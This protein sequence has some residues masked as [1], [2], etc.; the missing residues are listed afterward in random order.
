MTPPLEETTSVQVAFK[1]ANSSSV[2][3]DVSAQL[4]DKRNGFA[5]DLEC[6]N[7]KKF[8]SGL[9]TIDD[10]S[11]SNINS[12][13]A[14][15][16][17]VGENST[18]TNIQHGFADGASYALKAKILYKDSA[19]VI[20]T[21]YA[22][23]SYG[24]DSGNQ[25]L[26]S[27]N[28]LC[29]EDGGD[30]FDPEESLIVNPSE[31]ENGSDIVISCPIVRRQAE[32]GGYSGFDDRVPHTVMFT[33]D[34]VDDYYANDN[35]DNSEQITH[36]TASLPYNAEGVYTLVDCSLSNDSAYIVTVSA[37]YSDGHTVHAT[38]KDVCNAITAPVINSVT[39]YGLGDLQKG[40]GDSG[41]S[42]VME[43]Y[44][45]AA[46]APVK[47]PTV[48]NQIK[49]YLKQGD[50]VMYSVSLDRT[51]DIVDNQVKY[52][53][54]KE[55]LV[56]EE[57][58]EPV[59]NPNGS[60]TFD[61]TAT[62]DYVP[63]SQGSEEGSDIT[64]TSNIVSK[65]FTSDITPVT[66]VTISNAWI[67]A[68]VTTVDG[69]R[70]VDLNDATS[71]AGYNDAPVFAIAGQ[72][73]KNAFFGS[74]KWEGLHQDLDTTETKFKFMMRKNHDESDNP[75]A[76]WVPI[77]KLHL[78]QG[79]GE[80]SDQ[81]NVVSLVTS[82][83]KTNADGLFANIPGEAGV[84][85]SDQPNLYFMVPRNQGTSNLFNQEDSVE[86]S[87]QIVANSENT[88][89]DATASNK[90]VV[91]HKVRKY[92]QESEPRFTGSGSFGTLEVPIS[93]P[94]TLEGDYN[95]HSATF[96]S[97]L[98]SPNNSVTENVSNDGVFDLTV[99]DPSKR[100]PSNAVNYTVHYNISDPNGDDIRGPVSDSYEIYLNDEP[101]NENFSITEY[102]YKTFNNHGES[103]FQFKV[104]FLDGEATRADGINV[105][106]ESENNDSVSSN[107]ISKTL[108]CN[109]LRAEHDS[110]I[111][112]IVVLQAADPA[113]SSASDGVK[114]L[115]K[116]GVASTNTWFN[117][118]SG[119]V[120]FRAY[121]TPRVDSSDDTQFEASGYDH[122]E[123]IN[124][125]PRIDPVDHASVS[126]T[127]GVIESHRDT[128]MEWTNELSTKYGA[129]NNIVATH[130]VWVNDVD[131]TGD[132][133][134]GSDSYTVDISGD[135]YSYSLAL[136]VKIVTTN[137]ATTYY[138]RDIILDFD[139]VSVNTEPMDVTVARGSNDQQLKASFVKYSV[140]PDESKLN[141]TAVLLV[142]NRTAENTDPEEANVS[143]LSHSLTIQPT[144]VVNTYNISEYS[145]GDE[146]RLV[147]SVE[148][149]VDY[150]VSRIVSDDAATP[151][152]YSLDGIRRTFTD[153]EMTGVKADSTPSAITT[154]AGQDGWAI[155]NLVAGHKVNLYYYANTISAASTNAQNSFTLSQASGLGLY[156]IF[157]QNEDAK[158]YPYFIA[159]TVP[160]GTG[161]KASW[162]KSKVFISPA[163]AQP[164]P[165]G[166]PLYSGLTLAYSGTD[167]GSFPDIPAERRV[168]YDVNLDLAYSNANTSYNS[169]FVKFITLQT[170]GNASTTSA[171]DYDFQLL[172]TGIVTSHASFGRVSLVYNHYP[173]I[174]IETKESEPLLLTLDKTP[175]VYV[176][177]K[178]PSVNVNSGYTVESSGL[179]ANYMKVGLTL[180]AKGLHDEGLQSVFVILTQ[181]GDLTDNNSDLDPK[182]SVVLL[183]FDFDSTQFSTTYEQ[184]ADATNTAGSS[185]N[186]AANETLSLE[187]NG[188]NY[189]LVTG[190]LRSN[191]QSYVYIQAGSIKA[192]K[193][194][195]LLALVSTRCGTA[196]DSAVAE[197]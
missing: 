109:V 75:N 44:I 156:A 30:V 185:D 159:Y 180:D 191:D 5:I 47:I 193:D 160:T 95:F 108:V 197:L 178:K 14:Y 162:Y 174:A 139:S 45:G 167:D 144:G 89:P 21:Y 170:S 154:T 15:S 114:I 20:Q 78:I 68:S 29:R 61:V 39:A 79:D 18:S 110:A 122:E 126:L 88:L 158:Q 1:Q 153:Q 133:N 192:N 146:I 152:I 96:Q 51:D 13:K 82:M 17:K 71:L 4:H 91:V 60:Y 33:F 116:D 124:N 52:T 138:S 65:T 58:I 59:Q 123:D 102:S 118:R 70:M 2:L 140:A 179:Y 173:S 137:D 92:E 69:Q 142:D 34:E 143:A 93:N 50:S 157:Y 175:K 85:G 6:V 97:D 106:F 161:D 129:V 42:T 121:K 120:S 172:E 182:G 148:A 195:Q 119:T 189:H 57:G 131:K 38:L 84:S 81:E 86:I 127:G 28:F 194:I 24:T 99:S 104:E 186:I 26:S 12:S 8:V 74:G 147:V 72:F 181:E 3:Q 76:P 31:I 136:R 54:L 11:G 176:V 105:Y 80:S 43:V 117:F 77:Q 46:S 103:S 63:I 150:N 36:Y 184:Q 132:I 32:D 101:T 90:Q 145:L 115:N 196:Y 112:I 166:N 149:G 9:L 64:K 190:N 7:T 187:E 100:G 25:N 83:E 164:L 171:G 128:K 111:P 113:T 130:E 67:A 23:F 37:Y 165:S 55:D 56:K 22:S 62:L 94:I 107:N 125:I 135:P 155:K 151:G 10:H 169:E 188:Y 98:D 48:D 87:V 40:S 53:I 177:A 19:N 66:S 73:S 49:F 41:I 163:P 35:S 141:V 134:S 168:K 16:L 183:S 27:Y